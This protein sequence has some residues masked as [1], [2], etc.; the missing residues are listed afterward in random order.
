MLRRTLTGSSG[1]K[2]GGAPRS[3]SGKK[4]GVTKAGSQ[5]AKR[6]KT[7]AYGRQASSP[8]KVR[9]EHACTRPLGEV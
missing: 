6:V 9:R 5:D 1:K 8:N 3:G 4:A 2:A 7:A